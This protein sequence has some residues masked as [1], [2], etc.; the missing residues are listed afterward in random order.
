MPTVHDPD[1]LKGL[2][3][4]CKRFDKQK[5]RKDPGFSL[6]YS[7][8]ARL[9]NPM[10]SC[11]CVSSGTATTKEKTDDGSVGSGGSCCGS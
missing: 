8:F 11:V 1:S 7:Y 5:K 6:L 3:S 2:C 9:Y 10:N 4:T